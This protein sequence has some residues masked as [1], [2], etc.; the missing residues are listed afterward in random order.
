VAPASSRTFFS[1]LGLI[2]PEGINGG[3]IAPDLRYTMIA[4]RDI[5]EVAAHA[6]DSVTGMASSRPPVAVRMP[7]GALDVT[8]Q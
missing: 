5:C 7:A 4:S 3:P 8:P 6:F 2:K 1:T